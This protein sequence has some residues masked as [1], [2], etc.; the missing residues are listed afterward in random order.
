MRPA[1]KKWEKEF[2]HF[3]V[4]Y[5]SPDVT[6]VSA[7]TPSGSQQVAAGDS[8]L[9]GWIASS[10]F[11]ISYS[12]ATVLSLLSGALQVIIFLS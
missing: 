10:A 11:S 9:A 1:F 8:V 3:F 7:A 5:V 6:V 12:G 4:C 2:A